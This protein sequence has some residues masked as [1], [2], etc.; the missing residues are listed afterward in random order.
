MY[1]IRRSYAFLVATVDIYYLGYTINMVSLVAFLI[2]LG[3]IVDDAI[4]VT[5]NMYRHMEQGRPAHEAA[6]IGAHDRWEAF[7]QGYVGTE[8]LGSSYNFV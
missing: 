7:V 8:V 4:I 5:E 6:R 1:A 3:L 2:A